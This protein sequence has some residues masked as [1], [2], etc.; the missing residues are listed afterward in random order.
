M[1]SDDPES[2]ADRQGWW[3]AGVGFVSTLLAVPALLT[4]AVVAHWPRA[5]GWWDVLEVVLA[6]LQGLLLAVPAGLTV[7]VLALWAV[8]AYHYRA[9]T[10]HCW[11]CDRPL[12]RLFIPCECSGVPADARRWRFLRHC[13]RRLPAVLLAYVLI[14]AVAYVLVYAFGLGP[15]PA[16]VKNWLA[17]YVVLC[18]AV[19]F[20][21]KMSLGALQDLGRAPRLRLR[22]VPFFAMF[23]LWPITGAALLAVLTA[24][25]CR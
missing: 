10:Y 13:R 22:A 17:C 12:R 15:R 16:S 5:A 3:A 7:G 18:A 9:G 19:A 6:V 25:G 11:R 2:R 23:I 8:R 4:W 24:A 1:S 20:F 14:A 21:I